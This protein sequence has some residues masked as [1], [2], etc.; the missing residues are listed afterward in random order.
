M[1]LLPAAH[2]VDEP[3]EEKKSGYG[4][5]AV[6]Q[7]RGGNKRQGVTRE[8][9]IREAVPG[10]MDEPAK[11][12]FEEDRVDF[13]LPPR[14]KTDVDGDDLPADLAEEGEDGLL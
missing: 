7:K 8:A 4:R 10:S 12:A 5:G 14:P 13:V 1:N 3:G 6:R 11:L 2:F 9:V